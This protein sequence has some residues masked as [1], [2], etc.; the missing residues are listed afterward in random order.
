MLKKDRV[1]LKRKSSVLFMGFLA[2]SVLG[3]MFFLSS[4]FF[5]NE[6]IPILN[7]ELSSEKSISGSG[8]LTIHSWIYDPNKSEM[9]VTL[10][11][12]DIKS[13]DDNITFEAFQRNGE[14]Q[15]LE[16]KNV[17]EEDGIYV[18]KIFGLSKEFQ[19]VALDLIKVRDNEFANIEGFEEEEE[20]NTEL[21]AT[22]YSDQ[23]KVKKEDIKIKTEN[24]YALYLSNVLIAQTDNEVKESRNQVQNEVKKQYEYEKEIKV[25]E[26]KMIYETEQEKLETENIIS[27]YQMKIDDSRRL[28]EELEARQ[29][30][31]Q[32]KKDK[33]ELR[34]REIDLSYNQRKKEE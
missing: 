33:L 12:K 27:G 21:L 26:E 32:D 1:N 2:I 13:I 14:K 22:I 8:K 17:F 29:G 24:E 25:Y 16:V 15:N 5:M 11:T 18:L 34:K 30:I 23:R 10:I 9:E 19:Q 6:K 7:T 31:L 4:S 3:L 28:V 20:Q